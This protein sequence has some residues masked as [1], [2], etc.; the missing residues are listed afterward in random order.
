[1]QVIVT[2][3]MCMHVVA[4]GYTDVQIAD[5]LVISPNTIHAH[6]CSIY[7]KPGL[8]SCFVATRYALDACLL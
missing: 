8:S 5:A 1:M 3:S 6:L 2:I 7:S 4:Q